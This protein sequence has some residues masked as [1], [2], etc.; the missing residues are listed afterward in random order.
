MIST[1]PELTLEEALKCPRCKS[2]V[3]EH[4]RKSNEALYYCTSSKSCQWSRVV[5]LDD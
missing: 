1:K 4:L 3:V 2:P 5:R